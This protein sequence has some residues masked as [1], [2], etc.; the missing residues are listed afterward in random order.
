MLA[1]FAAT[2]VGILFRDTV[3]TYFHVRIAEPC[4]A[5]YWYSNSVRQSVCLSVCLSR[6]GIL[7]KRMNPI[8]RNQRW[9]AA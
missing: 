9:S 6:A 7:L 1:Q 5:W 8:S 3:Y 2:N 4:T